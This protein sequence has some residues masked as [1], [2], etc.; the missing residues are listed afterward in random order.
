M[1]AASYHHRPGEPLINICFIELI[2]FTSVKG[3]SCY[4][5]QPSG[6]LD[7]DLIQEDSEPRREKLVGGTK[8]GHA[9]N[10]VHVQLSVLETLKWKHPADYIRRLQ[11]FSCCHQK[12]CRCSTL[13]SF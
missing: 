5:S 8:R 2:G 6:L 1:A 7:D 4:N 9:V 10:C 12:R 11:G 3:G 13:S